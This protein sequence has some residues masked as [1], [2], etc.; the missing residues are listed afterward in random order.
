MAN[1]QHHLDLSFHGSARYRDRERIA[2]THRRRHFI[3]LRPGNLGADELPRRER[4]RDSAQQL[5]LQHLRAQALL[6]G[7]RRALLPCVAYVRPCAKSCLSHLGARSAGPRGRRLTALDAGHV[8]RHLSAAEARTS[9]GYVW[10]HSNSCADDRPRAGRLH[11][12]SF[13]LALDISH[14]CSCRD[15]VARAGARVR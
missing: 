9:N 13:L 10:L 1:R 15:A 14:Q 11:H 12:G 3:D 6:H 7:E 2:R 4:H 5:V 8:G